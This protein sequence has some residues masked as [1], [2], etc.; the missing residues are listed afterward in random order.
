MIR[1][2]IDAPSGSD[3]GCKLHRILRRGQWRGIRKSGQQSADNSSMYIALSGPWGGRGVWDGTRGHLALDESN[4]GTI[5][6]YIFGFC[7]IYIY[8]GAVTTRSRRESRCLWSTAELSEW[9]NPDLYCTNVGSGSVCG[10]VGSG[11]L[12]SPW[13]ASR[14]LDGLDRL[15]SAGVGLNRLV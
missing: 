10:R 9:Y 2:Y 8:N 5:I 3:V 15:G 4:F 14:Q 13:V 11:W 7:F 6:L 1:P 12:G